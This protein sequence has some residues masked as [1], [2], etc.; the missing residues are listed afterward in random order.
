MNKVKRKRLIPLIG[1]LLLISACVN[2]GTEASPTIPPTETPTHQPPTETPTSLTPTETPTPL[3]PTNTPEPTATTT[4]PT[5][6]T[7]DIPKERVEVSYED[8]VIRGTLVGEGDIAVIL[9]PMFHHSRSSWMP[10]AEHIAS[11]GYTA[12]PID[13]IHFEAGNS[14]GSFTSW[15]ALSHDVLAVAEFLRQRGHEQIA[16]MGASMGGDYCLGVA[17]LDPKITGVVVIAAPLDVAINAETAAT[18]LMPKLFVVGNEPDLVS[19]MDKAYKLLPMP[20]E[21]KKFID[22]AHGTNLFQ[23]D[24]KVEFRDLLVDFLDSLQ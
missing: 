12:L 22:S 4:I 3:P 6:P 7:P 16:C 11:L 17:L 18:L 19:I 21:F 8:R 1:I 20:K 23:S 2:Q 13:M 5:T 14:T 15:D 9:I 10:F 24:V